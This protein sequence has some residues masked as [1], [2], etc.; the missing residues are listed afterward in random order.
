MPSTCKL[1]IYPAGSGRGV[2]TCVRSAGCSVSS[3]SS[4]TLL[5][6]SPSTRPRGTE[7]AP[8]R[9]KGRFTAPPGPVSSGLTRSRSSKSSPRTICSCMFRW[10]A[11]PVVDFFFRSLA[12][13]LPRSAAVVYNWFSDTISE[14]AREGTSRYD[15][16][17]AAGRDP[18]QG[19]CMWL[20]MLLETCYSSPFSSKFLLQ[21]I[22]DTCPARAVERRLGWE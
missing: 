16:A 14:V 12:L 10:R 1:R 20:I 19:P 7:R 15:Q 11:R 3:T 2:L 22:F 18:H 8:L 6:S 9:G 17:Y 5:S 21:V 4:G 13:L